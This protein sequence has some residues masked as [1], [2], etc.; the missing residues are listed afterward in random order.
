VVWPP[1]ESRSAR[2]TDRSPALERASAIPSRRNFCDK[3]RPSLS[4]DTSTE[5]FPR[6]ACLSSTRTPGPA[7]CTLT[8][9]IE[10]RVKMDARSGQ[11]GSRASRDG[12]APIGGDVPPN[13]CPCW[14]GDPES[15]G[16]PRRICLGT[17]ILVGLREA[18]G[19]RTTLVTSSA[20]LERAR[21]K[22]DI[23]REQR[24]HLP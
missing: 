16:K 18:K 17:R 3:R 9:T 12:V 5:I 21:L 13:D 8:G 14:F 15:Q 1:T 10:N 23:R 4:A 11:R 24:S 22:N 20:L 6:R 7:K 2:Q 19:S